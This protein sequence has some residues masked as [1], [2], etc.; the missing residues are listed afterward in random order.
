[1][2]DLFR[3]LMPKE[4][5]FF[6][7]FEKHAGLLVEGAGALGDLLKGGET[8]PESCRRIGVF[9]EAADDVT[10]EAML[11]V[12]RTFITPFD[13]SD[14]QGLTTALDDTIDQMQKTARTALLFD[15]REFRPEMVEM[16]DLILQAS[17]V[18]MQAVPLLRN[19]GR[20]GAELTR[21][22]ERVIELEGRADE[23]HNAGLKAA[24]EANRSDPM[25]FYVAS[26]IYDHLEKVMDRF[27]DVA[28][29][30]SSIL[31]EHL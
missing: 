30:L 9:E 21:L 29:S 1:M 28:N 2:L 11:A 4:D 24:F 23:L 18:N 12:R 15:V 19:L 20:N 13:R 6:D 31:V 26:D 10:R 22:T 5:R 8:V 14:I 27:E 17:K 25:A 16:G 3:R 7:L